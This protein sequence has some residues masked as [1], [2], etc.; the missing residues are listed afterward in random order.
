MLFCLQAVVKHNCQ[1]LIQSVSF[2]K[3]APEPFIMA[4]LIRLKFE[5]FPPGEVIIRQGTKGDR[6]YFIQ[7]GIVE[8]ITDDGAVVAHLSEGAHFGEICLLTDDRRVATI[9]AGTM[10]DVFSLSKRKFQELLEEYPEMEAF[11]E[12]V[13]NERL[14]KIGKLPDEDDGS[15]TAYHSASYVHGAQCAKYRPI[16]SL[17]SALEQEFEAA[18]SSKQS[19]ETHTS[20][21]TIPLERSP[22]AQS[23]ECL[24]N[25]EYAQGNP[26]FVPHKDN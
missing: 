5:L 17:S 22:E 24:G 25:E 20:Y 23:P 12:N 18:S 9:R 14:S 21:K 7:K 11:F 15:P 8:V 10:C 2:F 26:H 3:D 1:E 13:A 6:M 16:R 19:Q 4:V